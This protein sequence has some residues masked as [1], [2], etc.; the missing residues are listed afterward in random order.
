MRKNIWTRTWRTSSV[1]HIII[2]KTFRLTP[3]ALALFLDDSETID[4]SSGDLFGSSV[5]FDEPSED[6]EE[7]ARE[8]RQRHA[9]ENNSSSSVGAVRG[10][11]L[12]SLGV[13]VRY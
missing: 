10:E 6:E 5:G 1:N 11:A 13:K 8:I 2:R 9:E 12:F 3:L 4:D 7:I